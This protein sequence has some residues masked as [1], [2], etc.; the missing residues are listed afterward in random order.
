MNKIMSRRAQKQQRENRES[1][2]AGVGPSDSVSTSTPVLPEDSPLESNTH[3]NEA[4][5]EDTPGSEH[6]MNNA[7]SPSEF[8]GTLEK[9]GLLDM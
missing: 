3:R 2:R 1:E 5:K 7:L 8:L 6:D 4:T 9:Q